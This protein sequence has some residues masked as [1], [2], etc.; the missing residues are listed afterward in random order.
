MTLLAPGKQQTALLLVR[1]SSPGRTTVFLDC[2]TPLGEVAPEELAAGAKVRIPWT[3]AGTVRL[4]AGPGCAQALTLTLPAPPSVLEDRLHRGGFG[5]EAAARAFLA[6]V[7][8]R[9]EKLDLPEKIRA[10]VAGL[11]LVPFGAARKP[12]QHADV[13]CDGVPDTLVLA[14]EGTGALGQA[15][16][17]RKLPTGEALADAVLE[18]RRL[19]GDTFGRLVVIRSG[20]A[21]E[22]HGPGEFEVAPLPQCG[23]YD[24][25][26]AREHGCA[27]V[28]HG[29]TES[30]AGATLVFDHAQ[31]KLVD[32]RCP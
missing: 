10:A 18:V 6:S 9:Q 14:V 12:L 23:G 25:V 4:S 16:A 17:T 27:A 11:G 1:G 19:D 7:L 26:W 15:L 3:R 24:R 29:T 32:V 28:E 13:D 30:Q 2:R 22:A 5:D 21:P 8:A 31:G 20:G